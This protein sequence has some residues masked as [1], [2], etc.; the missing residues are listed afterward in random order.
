MQEIE[1]IVSPDM[2]KAVLGQHLSHCATPQLAIALLRAIVRQVLFW[3]VVGHVRSSTTP[4][5]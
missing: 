3:L 5:R 4:R 2:L 1:S